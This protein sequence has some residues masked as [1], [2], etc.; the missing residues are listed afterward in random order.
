MFVL[1][2]FEYQ[3]NVSYI[4]KYFDQQ[5]SIKYQHYTRVFSQ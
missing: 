4:K 3:I 5:E 1:F 2:V